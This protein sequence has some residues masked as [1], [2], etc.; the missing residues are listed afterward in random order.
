MNVIPTV[1]TGFSETAR[2]VK[3]LLEAGEDLFRE[4]KSR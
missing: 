1:T 4:K 3:K 2:E